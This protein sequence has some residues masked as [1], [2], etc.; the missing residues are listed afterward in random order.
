M[1]IL[2]ISS[3]L[4]PDSTS[5]LLALSAYH[6]AKEAGYEA[7]LV[8]LCDYVLPICGGNGSFSD[9]N[10]KILSEKISASTAILLSGPVHTYNMAASA[11]NLVDLTG[12][13]WTANPVGLLV[14]AGGKSSYMSVLGFMNSLMLDYRCPIVPRY[15][16]ADSSGFDGEE[17]EA[18]IV[19]RIHV[20]VETVKHWGE[21]L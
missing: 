13:A 16:Y 19:E 9:P 3:S 1:S 8:D 21:V 10:V 12:K 15:V 7:E 18:E 14:S 4:N 2:V 11:K 20:L 5:R 17:I 6:Y